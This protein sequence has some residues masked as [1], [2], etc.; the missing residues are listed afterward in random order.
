MTSASPNIE[1][2]LRHQD[3]VRALARSLVADP[4]RADDVAQQTMLEAIERA[5]REIRHPKGW[6]AQVARNAAR[7]FARSDK[8][9]G[10]REQEVAK[11]DVTT[12][13]PVDAANRM[14]AHKSVVDALH[15]LEEP[16]RTVVMLRYFEE[17]E[18][19]QIADQVGRPVS[20]VRTQVQR[21]LAQMREKLDQRFGDRQAWCA[22]LLPLFT[23]AKV[24]SGVSLLAIFGS[25][26]MW[27]VF[28]PGAALTALLF[29]SAE[30]LW[31]AP[32]P[33]VPSGGGG[34]VVSAQVTSVDD[35]ETE[36]RE[37][38]SVAQPVE[39]EPA[40]APVVAKEGLQGRVLTPAGEPI[41]NLP[42]IYHDPQRPHINGTYLVVG[43]TSMDLN[44]PSVREQ[45]KTKFGRWMFSLE[46]GSNAK[47]VHRLI[48]GEEIKR[49]TAMTDAFGGFAFDRDYEPHYLRVE[50]EGLAI[51]GKGKMQGDERQV[52]IVGP[53]VDVTGNVTDEHGTPL[54]DAY[55][56]MGLSVGSLPGIGQ[57]M[58]D[59]QFE[60]WNA[61]TTSDGSF[62][63]KRLPRH[64]VLELVAQ[65][66]DHE[67]LRIKTTDIRGPM[68][69][70]LKSKPARDRRV[71]TGIVRSADGQ[72]AP[73]ATVALGNNYGKVDAGGRFVLEIRY[74]SDRQDLVAYMPGVQPALRVGFGKLLRQDPA[75]GK[76]LVLDLG[77][78]AL[79]ISGK[80]VD[81]KG[82]P[83][84]GARVLLADGVR[85]FNSSRWIEGIVGQ[86]RSEGIET[87]GEGRF[88][89]KGLSDRRY[90]IRA[91]DKDGMAVLESGPVAAGTK[92]LVMRTPEVAH[93]RLEGVVVDKHGNGIATAT[94]SVM[95]RL[96]YANNNGS[97][98]R[99][100]TVA[101]DASGNFVI[102]R[103]PVANVHLSVDG[104]GVKWQNFDLP[105]SEAAPRF[106]VS[107]EHKFKLRVT[108]GTKANRFKLVDA[109]GERVSSARHSPGI[110][111][112]NYVHG[113]VAENGP[114]YVVPDHATHLV[115]LN[116]K[117]EVSR[118]PL[119]LQ[120]IDLNII[121]I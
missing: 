26:A 87:D 36:R 59:S 43:N 4:S 79:A 7:T 14:E 90:N 96:V 70:V 44:Q 114:Y 75:L 106:V 40:P 35:V 13:E 3:W 23:R 8:R 56:H 15:E 82:K 28:V 93:R 109:N 21:G 113:I 39:D 2:L 58:T 102:E 84:R 97:L 33:P 71:L 52:F 94:V 16:Y 105:E 77:P 49:P 17:L 98:D 34:P 10:K 45:L 121:D 120:G 5:P 30:T 47:D 27:K 108:S 19:K 69:I 99:L 78:A 22:A 51:Y 92:D 38:P 81:A 6:L 74:L 42:I 55:I 115:L 85:E 91:I 89:L 110:E 31:N 72:P 29:V 53:A 67:S 46:W 116:G 1:T 112:H 62:V 54:E 37:A 73:R 68:K 41:A 11:S 25:L 61:H 65:K 117:E 76:D 63:M 104:A 60:S 64:A 83:V 32:E 24:V 18:P 20:T 107:R 66:R 119:N 103:C 118:L 48:C 101:C 111:S 57:R 86:Q 95:A 80:V 88:T 50:R 9:R 100:V 12:A